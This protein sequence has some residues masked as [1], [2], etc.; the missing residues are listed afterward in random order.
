MH[1]RHVAIVGATGAV[2]KTLLQVLE[3][4]SFP[5]SKL[6]LLASAKSQGSTLAFANEQLPLEIPS[7]ETFR[8][9]DIAFFCIGSGNSRSLAPLATDANA[10]VIDNSSAFRMEPHVPLIA[11]EVNPHSLKQHQG[12]I[13][14]PNCSTLAL[15]MPLAP[16]HHAFGVKRVVVATYQAVSGAGKRGIDELRQATSAY[17]QDQPFTPQ[18]F[19]YNC[20]FN[21]F[22][23]DSPMS[24]NG[25]CEEEQKIIR[26]TKKI[27]E[28]DSIAINATCVRVPVLRAHAEAVNVQF[29]QSVSPTQARQVLKT[30]P[31][32]ELFEDPENN[33]W[34]TPADASGKDNILVGRLRTDH[35]QQNTLDMWVVA[36]QL[37]KGAALNA[38]QIAELL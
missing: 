24:D 3:K 10:I 25:Y 30:A 16:L 23:H 26:E 28:D 7:K 8:G 33:R 34:P 38:V 17:L 9:V 22:P 11:P 2:G 36:D 5:I 37:L 29:T 13:A 27:M 19:P 18:V 12:I 14:N 21:L 31:G 15:V 20:A 6:T 35:S 1:S 4:R 32:L